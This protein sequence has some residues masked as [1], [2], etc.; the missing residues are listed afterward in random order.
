MPHQTLID[1]K[2]IR[3]QTIDQAKKVL[4]RTITLKL[5]KKFPCVMKKA[6]KNYS[7]LNLRKTLVATVAL[8]SSN[9]RLIN[10]QKQALI[11]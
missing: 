9:L 3:L 8:S 5:S 7:Y 2:L 6:A 11:A 4:F 1:L 10:K